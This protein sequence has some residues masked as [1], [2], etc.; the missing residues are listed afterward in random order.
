MNFINP[1]KTK[2]QYIGF[3]D[4]AIAKTIHSIKIILPLH[5]SPWLWLT[6]CNSS[7]PLRKLPWQE[8]PIHMKK[9]PFPLPLV[10]QMARTW[11]SMVL[12]KICKCHLVQHMIP[13][14]MV[15]ERS[16]VHK[17]ANHWKKN[18]AQFWWRRRKTINRFTIT[19][20][21]IIDYNYLNI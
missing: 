10:K 21:Y 15:Y 8:E 17:M 6:L 5:Y 12:L 13:I 18:V 16:C 11:P 9:K 3:C 14:R 19:E 2:S 1:S 4:T 7:A 20:F